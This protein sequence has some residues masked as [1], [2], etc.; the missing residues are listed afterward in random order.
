M[1]V[2]M[3][4]CGN[5]KRAVSICNVRELKEVAHSAT[6]TTVVVPHQKKSAT[7]TCNHTSNPGLTSNRCSKYANTKAQK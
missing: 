4:E 2:Y 5:T 3:C 7:E 1:Y 6:A